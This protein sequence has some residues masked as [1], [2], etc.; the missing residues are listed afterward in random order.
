MEQQQQMIT[1]VSANSG[2]QIETHYENSIPDELNN[3][4]FAMVFMMMIM[5]ASMIPGIL[6]GLTIK[7]QGN[8][9]ARLKTV[10]IQIILVVAIAACLGLAI[11]RIIQWMGGYDLPVDQLTPFVMICALGMLMIISGSIDLLG[12]AGIAVPA[13]IM[14]CGTAVA[15]L[16]YEYL[17]AFWQKYIY[18]WEPL[19]FIADGVREIIYRGGQWW[20]EY[21]SNMMVLVVIGA[22][23]MIISVLR[24][25]RAEEVTEAKE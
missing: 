4:Y 5:F 13:V 22:V 15:N 3:F 10:I 24:G 16:P 2:I 12:R 23:L 19:K 21:S 25:P 14:F 8:K 20:N 9:I 1:G 7:P 17:P 11:P 18:P 6:T